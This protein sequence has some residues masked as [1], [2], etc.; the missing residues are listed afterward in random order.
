MIGDYKPDL[1]VL[2]NNEWTVVSYDKK[3][4]REKSKEKKKNDL[5]DKIDEFV[6]NIENRNDFVYNLLKTN[7]I[8]PSKYYDEL[9]KEVEIYKNVLKKIRKCKDFT[10]FEKKKNEILISIKNMN[11]IINKDNFYILVGEGLIENHEGILLKDLAEYNE[12]VE[13]YKK[14]HDIQNTNSDSVL[15]SELSKKNLPYSYVSDN[16]SFASLFK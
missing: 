4:K 14:I 5:Q 2:N 7:S 10:Y 6:T 8:L 12:F 15:M 1:N 16:K 11:R 9:L 13:K 3:K